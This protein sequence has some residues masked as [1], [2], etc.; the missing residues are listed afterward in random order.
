MG[1]ASLRSLISVSSAV[2]WSLFVGVYEFFCAAGLLLL[3]SPVSETVGQLLSLPSTYSSFALAVPVSLAGAVVWWA[4]V[5]R[6]ETYTYVAGGVCGLATAL[7]T[8][9]F[10]VG[11]SVRV[12]GL[13]LVSTGWFLILFVFAVTAPV[14]A[15][16]VVPVV[17]ARRRLG[18]GPRERRPFT[19]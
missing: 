10:W 4:I 7:V 17:Y 3:L 11:Q 13:S 5:E 18:D 16:S 9:L 19:G 8:M 14:A 2:T 1:R 15:L 12:W 6:Q